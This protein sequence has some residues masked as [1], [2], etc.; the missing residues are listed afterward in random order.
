MLRD[1]RLNL[2]LRNMQKLCRL[3]ICLA[4]SEFSDSFSSDAHEDCRYNG[5]EVFVRFR[6]RQ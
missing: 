2:E 3:D 5:V 1:Q 4:Y 6:W